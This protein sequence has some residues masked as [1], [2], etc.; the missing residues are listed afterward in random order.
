[1]NY[2]P[3]KNIDRYSPVLTVKEAMEL[4]HYSKN[5]VLGLIHAGVIDATR[6]GERGHWRVSRDSIKRT[7]S[8]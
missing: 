4:L 8:L 7:F 1:M 3:I 5:T 6:N 2:K